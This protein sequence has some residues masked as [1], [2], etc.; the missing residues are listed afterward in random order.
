MTYRGLEAAVFMMSCD[1]AFFCEYIPSFYDEL[2]YKH[3]F[4]SI[5]LL[6][7]IDLKL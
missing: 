4:V 2:K 7:F 5:Y 3:A 1:I 6:L